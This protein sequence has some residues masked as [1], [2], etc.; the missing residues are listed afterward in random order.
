VV[1][2]SLS[3]GLH[4]HRP[5]TAPGGRGDEAKYPGFRYRAQGTNSSS[6]AGL[7]CL[8]TTAFGR[9]GVVRESP[10]RSQWRDRPGIG[11][12]RIAQL[13][14]VPPHSSSLDPATS[15]L[16]GRIVCLAPA[17]LR[18]PPVGRT[19]ARA[20]LR[21]RS[22]AAASPDRDDLPLRR[23]ASRAGPPVTRRTRCPA[24]AESRYA[25]PQS[26]LR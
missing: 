10:S 3:T 25:R 14:G 12:R 11:R 26:R 22:V 8:P 6:P 23:P 17:Q 4:A 9:S 19:A 20:T 21:G 2:P 24:P 7:P 1:V 16:R 5:S 18:A 15:Q 13:T